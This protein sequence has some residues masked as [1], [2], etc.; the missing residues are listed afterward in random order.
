MIR[1]PQILPPKAR[2]VV[3]L[4]CGDGTLG[5][6]FKRIQ[7]ACRYFGIDSSYENVREAARRIDRAAVEPPAPVDLLHYGLSDIDCILCHASYWQGADLQ[8]LLA[9]YRQMLSKA[10]QIVLAMDLQYPVSAIAPLL[11][12]FGPAIGQDTD[13]VRYIRLFCGAQAVP[14]GIRTLTYDPVCENI[15]V[16][17]PN[18]FMQTDP[19]ILI[20]EETFDEQLCFDPLPT[21]ENVLLFERLFITNIEHPLM[22]LNRAAAQH[23]VLVHEFDDLPYWGAFYKRNLHEE[24]DYIAFR[25]VHAVQTTTPALADYFRAYNPYVLTFPNMLIELP[26]ARSFDPRAEVV[27]IFFGA[28]NREADWQAIMPAINAAI[29][30]YGHRLRFKVTAD[31]K[32]F[33]ALQTEAKEYVGG[34]YNE[35]KFAPYELYMEAMH[36]SDLA[37]LPLGDTEFNRMKSDLKFIEAAGNG[38]VVIA[39]PTVYERTVRDGRTGFLYRSPQEFSELLRILV[40]D[41]VLRYETATLAYD[42]VRRN[43]LLAQHY[44]ERIHAYR[45]LATHF[46]MLESARQ[47]RIASYL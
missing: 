2:T 10:G 5:A 14:L 9:A 15:R 3:E 28:V 42:Y 38:A 8:A 26:E 25:G 16:R 40:E 39:S 27:T 24:T 12:P 45:E 6:A 44:E 13:G 41:P 23:Q 34:A 33:D 18:G 37:L 29:A 30:R 21:Q 11:A 22:D 4:G 19:G 20:E 36:E 31:K 35:G 43:R 47:A 17:L 32:F 7:P 1:Y 46:E